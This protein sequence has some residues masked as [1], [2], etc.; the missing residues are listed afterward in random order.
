MACVAL[1]CLV[2]GS[3]WLVIREGL[4]DLPPFTAAGVRFAVATAGMTLVARFVARREGGDRAPVWL[5]AV[6]GTTNFA[7]SYGIVY[8]C[9]TRLPSGLVSV[10]WAVFPLMMAGAG[11]AWIPGE[12]LAG[13][14]W[15]GFLAGFAGVV[16]LFLTDLRAIGPGAIPAGALLLVSPAISAVGTAVVKRWG[17]RYSSTLLNRDGMGIGA[18]ILLLLAWL[19]EGNERVAWTA[20]AIGSVAYLALA[21]TVLTFGLFFW[22]MRTHAAHRLSL[23]AYVIPAVALFLGWAVAGEPVGM[24]TIAGAVLIAGGCA[25]VV[26]GRELR[27]GPDGP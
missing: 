11:H 24:P 3:T 14:H 26:G 13:R 8:W 17:T 20:R 7:A 5:A 16:L 27:G 23:I 10:L 25:A 22:L 15:A 12:R 6:M 18:G 19:V 9:E 4:E 21:G 2:W 1:L